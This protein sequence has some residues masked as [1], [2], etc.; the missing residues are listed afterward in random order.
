MRP[1]VLPL[2]LLLIAAAPPE[3]GQWRDQAARVSIA[4]D[5]F[6]IAHVQGPTD[7]DAV[8]GM[9]YAQAED[10]FPRIEANYLTALGRTAEADGEKAIWQDLRA[11]LYVGEPELKAG[12]A[13]SPEWLKKLMNAWA[14]GL[15]YYLAT[16]PQVKPR[17]LVRFE[18]WMAL[19]FTEGS[20]GG[21][22]ERIDLGERIAAT[23]ASDPAARS[24]Y[25]TFAGGLLLNCSEVA[26]C[27]PAP[28]IEERPNA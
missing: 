7:A 26:C 24:A 15:N 12:Y 21:D 22:I 17:V 11:R 8:F 2:T 10:D 27:G 19:S 9:I 23:L 3:I 25:V 14:A 28:A 1:F 16:H 18:P 4:R 6:G 5:D 13:A 20:I